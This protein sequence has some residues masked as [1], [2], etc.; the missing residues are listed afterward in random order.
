MEHNVEQLKKEKEKNKKEKEDL[1]KA[2]AYAEAVNNLWSIGS[3][4]VMRKIADPNK[5][6]TFKLK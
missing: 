5:R 2:M 6:E 3:G 1:K 4:R